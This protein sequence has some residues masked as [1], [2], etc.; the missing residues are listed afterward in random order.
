M[1]ARPDDPC[2]FKP[3]LSRRSCNVGALGGSQRPSIARSVTT[4]P[5]GP[6]PR[7]QLVCAVLR[8]PGVRAKMPSTGLTGVAGLSTGQ[9]ER[10]V[11]WNIRS[12]VL[13]GV[14]CD[15]VLPGVN[16]EGL[17]AGLQAAPDYSSVDNYPMGKSKG[18]A[19]AD[20]EGRCRLSNPY[21]QPRS[22]S[23]PVKRSVWLIAGQARRFA[24]SGFRR[25][26]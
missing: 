10:Q 22:A 14:T 21:H 13:T 6:G 20:E 15:P 23:V 16:L 8:T 3:P 11:K 24:R 19:G 7:Q 18:A 9:A 17:C 4:T 2:A 26:V 25:G 12:P 1:C 5:S